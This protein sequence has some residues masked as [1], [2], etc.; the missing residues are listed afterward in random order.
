[1][2]RQA[3]AGND[4]QKAEVRAVVAT[5]QRF[6]KTRSRTPWPRSRPR[7]SNFVSGRYAGRSAKPSARLRSAGSAA[8]HGE[9]L[10][11]VRLPVG[12]AVQRRAGCEAARE[13]A[14][15]RRLDQAALVVARLVPRDRGRRRARRRATAGAIIVLEHLDRV[16]LDDAQ[17]RRGRRSPMRLQQRADARRMDLDAE[18]VD[19]AARPAR[20]PRSRR[21]CRS[22]SRRRSGAT[23]PNSAAKS[24]GAGANGTT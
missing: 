14:H 22:R 2:R 23:R 15:E 6:S 17:V 13:Q 19:V 8:E 5:A 10:L 24:S 9:H 3:A 4:S 11:G 12:R 7:C 21:P 18:E 16:V 20:S 1:M